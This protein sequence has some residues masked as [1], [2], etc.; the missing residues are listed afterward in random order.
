[1]IGVHAICVMEVMQLWGTSELRELDDSQNIVGPI[2]LSGSM[3][4]I[5]ELLSG[6][7]NSKETREARWMVQDLEA[8][9]ELLHR[10]LHLS[11]H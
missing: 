11:L 9:G 3:G 10:G 5:P 6:S 4:T 7:K 1:M 2:H 8:V